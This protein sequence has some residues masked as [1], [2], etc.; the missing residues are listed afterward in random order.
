MTTLISWVK[1]SARA[2]GGEL[3][4]KDYLEGGGD[5]KK[6]ECK[7]KEEGDLKIEDDLWSWGTLH[8][9]L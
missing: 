5:F 8:H 4:V 1:T 7:C 2:R 9:L 6:D 3:M